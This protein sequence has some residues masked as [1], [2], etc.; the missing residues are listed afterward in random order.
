M[1][2]AP[3][4][5]VERLRKAAWSALTLTMF[6]A[7]VEILCRRVGAPDEQKYIQMDFDGDLMWGLGNGPG[8]RPEYPVNSLGLRGDELASVGTPGGGKSARILTLGDSSIYGHGVATAE[9]FGAVVAARVSAARGAGGQD[10][11][12]VE[13]VNGGVPGYST[14]QSLGLLARLAPIV[15]PDVVIVGNL[16][17][18]ACRAAITDR[19]WAA[20]LAGAY[21]PWQPIV[22]P[23]ALLTDHSALARRLRKTVHDRVSPGKGK[24]NEIGWSHLFVPEPGQA[25]PAKGG[26][27]A[28][29]LSRVPLDEYVANLHALAASTRAAGGLPAFLLLPHPIDA[30]QGVGPVERSYRDALRSVAAAEHAPLIDGAAWFAAHPTDAPRFSDDIHPNTLGHAELATAVLEAF[31]A[32][33]AIA[34]RLGIGR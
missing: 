27:E 24:A 4:F 8:E 16:W 1:H 31:A 33:D 26:M 34:A 30:E 13:A 6:L 2:A 19:A 28:L 25:P 3:P 18:D 20:E 32:D 11:G 9:V 5:A 7:F 23:L 15:H 14:F 22:A 29:S 21:G 12:G 17:S 10:A